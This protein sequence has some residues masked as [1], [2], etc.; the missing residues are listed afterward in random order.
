MELKDVAEAVN[1]A[2]AATIAEAGGLHGQDRPTVRTKVGP[3]LLQMHVEKIRA[4]PEVLAEIGS[5]L[6]RD[7]MATGRTCFAPVEVK[8]TTRLGRGKGPTLYRF[9]VVAWS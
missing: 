8:E 9:Q 4:T 1:L 3:T 2:L 7:G 5:A 6:G